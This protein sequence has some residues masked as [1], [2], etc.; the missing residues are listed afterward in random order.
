MLQLN[1]FLRDVVAPIKIIGLKA[2]V[3][4]LTSDNILEP[5]IIRI[6]LLRCPVGI[7][8]NG[9]DPVLLGNEIIY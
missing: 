8:G 9:F 2:A 7:C 6:L 1:I 3:N 4:A 5:F